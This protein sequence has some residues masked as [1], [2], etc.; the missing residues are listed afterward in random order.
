MLHQSLGLVHKVSTFNSNQVL[1]LVLLPIRH[2]Q[3][4][5]IMMMIILVNVRMLLEVWLL[6]QVINNL[7]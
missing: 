4:V 6:V 2:V 7:D 5:N 3:Q 1:M